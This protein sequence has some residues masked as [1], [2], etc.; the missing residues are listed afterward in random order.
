MTIV[1]PPVAFTA[2]ALCLVKS[3]TSGF[4]IRSTSSLPSSKLPSRSSIISCRTV[5]ESGKDFKFGIWSR[6]STA[7]PFDRK[8]NVNR[9]SVLKVLMCWTP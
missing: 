7:N 8:E 3:N 9:M 5:V 6:V 4:V 2:T 1:T